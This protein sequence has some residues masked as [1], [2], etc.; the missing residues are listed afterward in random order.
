MKLQAE[1]E[2]GR[3]KERDTDRQTDWL[4]HKKTQYDPDFLLSLWYKKSTASILVLL[5]IIYLSLPKVQKHWMFV[6]KSCGTGH[7]W[8]QSNPR[9]QRYPV[10]GRK[11]NHTE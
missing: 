4:S 5:F 10:A 11:K 8:F 7:H 9:E 6:G 1:K 2:S 3:K